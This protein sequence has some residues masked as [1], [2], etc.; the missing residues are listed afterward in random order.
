MTNMRSLWRFQTMI[1]FHPYGDHCNIGNS[2]CWLFNPAVQPPP[3]S[4]HGIFVASSK[5][6]VR[7]SDSDLFIAPRLKSCWVCGCW[8]HFSIDCTQH[9]DC[10]GRISMD[11]WDTSCVS[12]VNENHATC[13]PSVIHRKLMEIV[14]T[15]TKLVLGNH[16]WKC[17]KWAL[18]DGNAMVPQCCL[19]LLIDALDGGWSEMAFGKLS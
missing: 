5:V 7:T 17:D 10:L 2:N 19:S 8:N 14:S 3:R 4:E 13:Q 16:D 15:S 18:A 12:S 9:L 1:D 6:F 11:F